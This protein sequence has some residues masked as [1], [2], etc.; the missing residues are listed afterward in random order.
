MDLFAQTVHAGNGVGHR[1][2]AF[3]GGGQGLLGHTGRLGGVA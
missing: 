3:L 1:Q 2:L